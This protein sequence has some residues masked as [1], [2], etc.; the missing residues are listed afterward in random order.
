MTEI[1]RLVATLK[2]RFKAAGLSYRDVAHALDLSEASVKR[3]LGNGRITVERL[4]Q[5]CD[6]LGLTMGELL[7]EVETSTPRLHTLTPE[8]EARLVSDEKFLLVTV[9]ALNHWSIDDLVATYRLT[10]AECIKYL[11]ALDR[12][13]LIKLKPGNRIQPLVARDFDWLPGG[14]IRQYFSQHG[15]PD[16]MDSRFDT[17]DESMGFIH[18][19][20][21]KGALS[22]LNDELFKLRSKFAALHDLS[23]S[24]PLPER[25]GTALVLAMRAWEPQAFRSLRRAAGGAFQ[26][27]SR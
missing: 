4:A 5:I 2:H 10:A 27:K 12:M 14:P 23:S 3:L 9:C 18:G 16:F 15:L 11:L 17:P 25:T 13:G 8:Q 21:T 1:A 22:Q 26:R 19:M 6:L 24:A 20:L 7:H